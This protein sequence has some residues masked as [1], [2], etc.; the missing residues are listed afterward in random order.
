VEEIQLD[1][2]EASVDGGRLTVPLAGEPSKEF[3]SQL[4]AVIER[5]QRGSDAWGGIEVGKA[6]LKIEAVSADAAGDLRH[7]LES[8]VLQANADLRAD[9]ED[10]EE[11]GDERSEEDQKLT[12]AFRAFGEEPPG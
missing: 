10:E 5:L 12:D 6:K 11:P 7:F 1:W 4:S 8:A 3:R 9:D 2:G